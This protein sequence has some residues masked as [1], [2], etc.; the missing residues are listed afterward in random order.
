VGDNSRAAGA[1]AV[2]VVLWASAFVSIRSAG[3][4]FSPGALALGRLLVAS[5]ALGVMWLAS[6]DGWPPRAAWPGILGSGVLWFGLYMIT[7]NWGEREVDAGTAAM[8]VTIGPILIALLGGWLLREGFPRRLGAGMA[9]SLAGAIVVGVAESGG[10]RT[11]II[12]VVLC[13]A[14]AVCYA[15][16]VVFQKP[17]LGHAS[18][19]QVTTFGCFAG[20][21]TKLL[22]TSDLCRYLRLGV[23][24]SCPSFCLHLLTVTTHAMASPINVNMPA[25]APVAQSA[26]D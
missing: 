10:G 24:G 11:S 3:G 12:G 23:A 4:H 6:G 13:A 16:G 19:V 26:G 20:A 8:V 22:A 5:L 14:A 25:G 2:T 18:A 21:T 1:A 15:A 17:A 7:L 9:V